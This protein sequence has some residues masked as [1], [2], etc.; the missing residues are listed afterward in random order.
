MKSWQKK[1]VVGVVWW[2]IF[3]AWWLNKIYSTN[4]EFYMF[5][6]GSWRHIYQ[7]FLSGWVVSSV[8]DWIFVIGLVMS[9]PI[10]LIGWNL[11]LKIQW[12]KLLVGGL[13]KVKYM[14]L[15]GWYHIAG[16]QLNGGKKRKYTKKK[17]HKKVRPKPLHI[18]QKSL[19]RQSKSDESVDGVSET[20]ATQNVGKSELDKDLYPSRFESDGPSFLDDE[21][22]ANIPLDDIQL[23]DREVVN[24][25]IT[26]L[27]VKNGYAIISE[28]TIGDMP[29]SYVAVDKSHIYILKF[30]EESGDWLAGEEPFGGEKPFWFSESSHRISPVCELD[31]MIRAFVKRLNG[32]GIRHQVIPVL[33]KREGNIINAEDMQE[34]WHKMNVWVC[35]TYKGGPDELQTVTQIMPPSEGSASPDIVDLIQSAF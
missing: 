34:I 28:A 12:S 26:D 14:L 24:E 23:P 20:E 3:F 10:Y 18:T 30:D 32:V 16:K 29:V 1:L 7:E 21:D 8:S 9:I 17:S 6:A 33:V 31:E 2:A 15:T 22:I 35:R 4:W 19:E 5:Q 27:L 13:K 11:L 25:D